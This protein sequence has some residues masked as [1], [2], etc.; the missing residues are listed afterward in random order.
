MDLKCQIQGIPALSSFY[1]EDENN[2]KYI[3]FICEEMLKKG[4]I[5]NNVFYSSL[6]HT[7]NLIKKYSKAFR[8]TCKLLKNNIVS[9]KFKNDSNSKSYNNKQIG[10]LN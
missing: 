7:D 8:E 1:F 6:G 3:N 9:N 2:S 4:F 5:A 10:R